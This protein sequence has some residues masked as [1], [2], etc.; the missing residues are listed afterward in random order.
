MGNRAAG[1]YRPDVVLLDFDLAGA[2]PDR[3]ICAVSEQ[4][5]CAAL[6]GF[7]GY[8]AEFLRPTARAMLTLHL[9]KRTPLHQV[10]ERVLELGRA[11][12]RRRPDRTALAG[13][14]QRP[15][16]LPPAAG[17]S[18]FPP[19]SPPPAPRKVRLEEPV[20]IRARA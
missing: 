12:P 5:P 1:R 8:D 15:T 9:D 13:R 10:S 4:V 7:S 16:G 19:Q 18:T 3:L 14:R 11:A 20:D 17:L 2:D 6:V